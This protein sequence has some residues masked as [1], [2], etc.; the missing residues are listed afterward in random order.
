MR[1]IFIFLALLFSTKAFCKIDTLET[2]SKITNVTVF[3]NGA[4]VKR[5]ASIKLTKG[6]FFISIDKLPQNINTKS[7]QVEGMK[8]C[9]ILSVKHQEGKTEEV[10]KEALPVSLEAR[11]NRKQFR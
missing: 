2:K 9:K 6:Q 4:Q 8:N 5:E 7:I 11:I 1:K 10:K 3:F